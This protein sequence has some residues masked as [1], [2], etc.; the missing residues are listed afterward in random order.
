MGLEDELVPPRA[1]RYVCDPTSAAAVPAKLLMAAFT[2]SA[3]ISK[4]GCGA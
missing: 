3:T 2:I 1:F 4:D